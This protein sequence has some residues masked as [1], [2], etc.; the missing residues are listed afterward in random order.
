M[1]SEHVPDHLHL[2]LGKAF[3]E[4]P[5]I[6]IKIG[7]LN[8]RSP[9]D[10]KLA[11][12]NVLHGNNCRGPIALFGCNSATETWRQ[13]LP[14]SPLRCSQR[15]ESLSTLI[16]PSCHQ[17]QPG[18]HYQSPRKGGQYKLSGTLPQSLGA[19][20]RH[21]AV[22]EIESQRVTNTMRS[23]RERVRCSCLNHCHTQGRSNLLSRTRIKIWILGKEEKELKLWISRKPFGFP[24]GQQP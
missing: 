20:G 9:N 14:T 7:R 10:A 23:S 16:L 3:L 13:R 11:H 1:E 15:A 6:V 18:A 8:M 22:K 5:K 21:Q 4:E 19:L 2:L 12:E 24:S 17:G